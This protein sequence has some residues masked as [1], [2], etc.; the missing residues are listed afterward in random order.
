MKE[1][2]SEYEIHIDSNSMVNKL[3]RIE[4]Y[5]LAPSKKTLHVECDTLSALHKALKWFQTKSFLHH[6]YSH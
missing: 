5:S 2:Q 1:I 3:A 6:I 4:E